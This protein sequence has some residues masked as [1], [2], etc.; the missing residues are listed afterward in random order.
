[1]VINQVKMA[2]YMFQNRNGETMWSLT[3]EIE[4]SHRNYS[5]CCLQVEAAARQL[6]SINPSCEVDAVEM[7]IPMP[8]HPVAA[9]E[10]DKVCAINIKL[11]PKT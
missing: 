2:T 3:V 9:I 8:G 1:M 11:I 10:K 4:I 7:S 6:K 5:R